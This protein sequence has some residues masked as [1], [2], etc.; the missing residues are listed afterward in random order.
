MEE[1]TYD[2]HKSYCSVPAIVA[3][4]GC[5]LSATQE[6]KWSARD[7][8]FTTKLR[9]LFDLVITNSNLYVG[10]IHRSLIG[11][12]PSYVARTE[13]H[14]AY[15]SGL[16]DAGIIPMFGSIQPK[17]K[18]E[19]MTPDQLLWFKDS[20]IRGRNGEPTICWGP[21]EGGL[22]GVPL[23]MGRLPE[24]EELETEVALIVCATDPL[25]LTDCACATPGL[26]SW[27]ARDKLFAALERR[28]PRTYDRIRD[29]LKFVEEMAPT[30]FLMNSAEFRTL[31]IAMGYDAIVGT[32]D[33]SGQTRSCRYVLPL[34]G[35]HQV[36][37]FNGT[38][39]G[40]PES[41]DNGLG[42]WK[43]DGVDALIS[44]VV[45]HELWRHRH[46]RVWLLANDVDFNP[47]L[48][49]MSTV[50]PDISVKVVRFGWMPVKR[51]A[52]C[53]MEVMTLSRED[54]AAIGQ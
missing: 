2:G 52:E 24:S 12:I 6:L 53:P 33:A 31:A 36:R 30:Q 43:Q 45:S 38:P 9:A 7:T 51:N 34:L 3:D 32:W 13:R 37:E 19:L 46:N 28:D 10:N 18:L 47:S 27:V 50:S 16:R 26:S 41:R 40:L 29:M 8:D 35:T 21:A 1:K 25:D 54:V 49:F 11:A 14:R 39:A 4:L 22:F 48:W 17:S 15:V 5:V 44:T 42:V 23:R 20:V